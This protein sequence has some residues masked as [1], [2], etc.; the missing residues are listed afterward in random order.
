MIVL[1]LLLLIWPFGTASEDPKEHCDVPRLVG[2]V[3]KPYDDDKKIELLCTGL[4]VSKNIILTIEECIPSG[5]TVIRGSDSNYF[6]MSGSKYWSKFCNKNRIIDYKEFNEVGMLTIE[7]EFSACLRKE[8]IHLTEDATTYSVKGWKVSHRKM[9]DPITEM[10][11]APTDIEKACD[12]LGG[13]IFAG[14]KIYGLVKKKCGEPGE[15]VIILGHLYY[16]LKQNMPE[17]DIEQ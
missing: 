5:K 9:N 1:Y 7:G 4:I 2:I 13:P 15:P 3:R 16:T 6:A 12:I 17:N 10:D 8:T 14:N 11:V